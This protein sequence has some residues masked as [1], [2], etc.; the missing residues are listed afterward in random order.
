MNEDNVYPVRIGSRK[1]L[2]QEHFANFNPKTKRKKTV[3]ASREKT[4]QERKIKEELL[5]ENYFEECE[6]ENEAGCSSVKL[7]YGSGVYI[8]ESVEAYDSDLESK[9]YSKR[10]GHLT[11]GGLFR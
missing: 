7:E 11:K 5:D 9:K 8:Y 2:N 6:L 3:S 4:I 10:Q 1:L